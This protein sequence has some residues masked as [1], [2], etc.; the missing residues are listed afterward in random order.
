MAIVIFRLA[1][2]CKTLIYMTICGILLKQPLTFHRPVGKRL[3][4]RI[5]N[6]FPDG[7]TIARGE[8]NGDYLF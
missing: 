5:F 8:D 2:N 7:D 4:L 3:K 1:G 6:L